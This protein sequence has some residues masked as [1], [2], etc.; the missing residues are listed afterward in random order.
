MIP[1]FLSR[2]DRPERGGA[3][4]SYLES[5]PRRRP[6]PSSPGCSPTSSPRPRPRSR[7]PSGI[8]KA[9]T[10]CWRPSATRTRRFR[11][12][13]SLERVRRLGADERGALLTAYVG[14]RHN[15]RHKPGRAFERTAYRFDVLGDYGAFRDM[16]RHRML[17]I[18]WQTLSPRHGYELPGVGR[19]GRA[20]GTVRRSARTLGR[21]ARRARHRL[22]RAGPVRG[23]TRLPHAIRRCT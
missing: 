14:E 23:V 1:S 19:R 5:N 4:V 8:P 6:T 3:W 22:P 12:P 9:K 7:S 11:R 13:S 15:R 17:T 18:E 16:Q 10:R 21:A 20:A 2:L